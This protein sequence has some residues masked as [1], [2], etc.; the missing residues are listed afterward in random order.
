[1][2]SATIERMTI[3]PITKPEVSET[4]VSTEVSRVLGYRKLASHVTG[5]SK[6]S[7][8]YNQLFEAGIKP[9]KLKSVDKYKRAMKRGRWL[10]AWGMQFAWAAAAIG[11]PFCMAKSGFSEDACGITLF[12][13][14]IAGGL[15]S[16]ATWV[17]L[18]PGSWDWRYKTLFGYDK[19]I[20]IHVL[21]TALLV[22]KK[23]SLQAYGRAMYSDG[24]GMEL[25][26]EEFCYEQIVLD[27]FLVLQV[28]DA[29]IY[30]EVWDEPKFTP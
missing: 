26:V 27:P 18:S 9:L 29:S 22:S 8:V 14:L 1:M 25:R 21:N 4:D 3:V 15:L 24:I 30:L 16:L 10:K 20:P 2:N 11:L 7:N 28:G 23:L 6:V 17:T 5:L 12:L 13:S 19:E